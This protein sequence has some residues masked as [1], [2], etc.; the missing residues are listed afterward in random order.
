MLEK[1]LESPLD[2]KEILSAYPEG[3]E[4]WILIGRTDAET[5]TPILWPPD[6][7]S[8][9]IWKDP[10]AVK[11]W[12][13]EEKGTTEDEML[14]WHHWLMDMSLSKLRELVRTEQLN[15]TEV[16]TGWPVWLFYPGTII[17]VW[18]FVSFFRTK[19]KFR[20]SGYVGSKIS[21]RAAVNVMVLE[22]NSNFLFCPPGFLS[23]GYIC[24]LFP[25][26]FGSTLQRNVFLLPWGFQFSFKVLMILV[27]YVVE[28]KLLFSG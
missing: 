23:F 6:A 7:K 24:S 18:Q 19:W 21:Q 22:T 2:C 28:S 16:A 20:A 5:E 12:R 27:L 14:G 1:T 4:S 15:L 11:G 26:I 3:N 13:C 8:W 10:D 25:Q 9:L 17:F